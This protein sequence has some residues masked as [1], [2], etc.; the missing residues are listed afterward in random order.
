MQPDV[1]PHQRERHD[2]RH[3]LRGGTRRSPPAARASSRRRRCASDDRPC[4]SARW[5]GAAGVAIRR[6]RRHEQRSRRRRAARRFGT[7]LRTRDEPAQFLVRGRRV[8]QQRHLVR[9]VKSD[10][11]AGRPGAG[12]ESL[13]RRYANT[14]SMKFSRSRGSESRP[15]SSTGRF[16]NR[17]HAAPSRTGRGPSAPACASAIDLHAL[18]AAARR[19]LLEDVAGRS[20]AGQCRRTAARPSCSSPSV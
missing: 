2:Q 10:E 3:E 11:P 12:E 16:G 18:H 1:V 8:R 17:V 4:A 9:G 6:H 19:I 7:R 13:R 14:R 20:L 5:C 15:S